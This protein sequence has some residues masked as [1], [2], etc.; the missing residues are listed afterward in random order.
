VGAPLSIIKKGDPLPRLRPP[1]KREGI[2]SAAAEAKAAEEDD[3]PPTPLQVKVGIVGAGAA[4]LFTA[5]TL[6]YLNT[7]QKSVVFSYEILEADPARSGGRLF[8]YHFS[9]Q[10]HDYFDVGV[11]R[12]PDHPIMTRCVMFVSQS[13]LG[14]YSDLYDC[15]TFDLFRTLGGMWP[16]GQLDLPAMSIKTRLPG[17]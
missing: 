6:D 11:M 7:A 2:L 13:D 17:R 8:T 3:P 10:G 12:F 16:P 15:S 14:R 9:G 5:L 4:G 1:S